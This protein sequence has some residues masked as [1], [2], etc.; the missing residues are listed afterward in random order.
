MEIIK[1]MQKWPLSPNLYHFRSYSGAEVDLVLEMNGILYPIEIKTKSNP[2]LKDVRG[3][4]AFRECFPKER[5]HDGL[6][7]C[8][9]EQPRRLADN[10]VA[11]PWWII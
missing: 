7:I 10:V 6:L 5:I 1:N 2:N 4:A 3:F 9:I 8:S 11:V